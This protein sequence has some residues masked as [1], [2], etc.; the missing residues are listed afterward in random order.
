MGML[1]ERVSAL[2]QYIIT[3][4]VAERDLCVTEVTDREGLRRPENASSGRKLFPSQ[5]MSNAAFSLFIIDCSRL[6]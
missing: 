5:E 4:F 6:A 2:L 1:R 3:V